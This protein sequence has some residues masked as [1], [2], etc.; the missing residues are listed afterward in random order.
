MT[1]QTGSNNTPAPRNEMNT[2][3]TKI[4]NKIFEKLNGRVSTAGIVPIIRMNGFMK[5]WSGNKN[6]LALNSL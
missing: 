6:V 3:T 5:S 4:K 1:S 2:R